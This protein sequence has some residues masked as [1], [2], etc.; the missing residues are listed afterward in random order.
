MTEPADRP[1][2]D[3]LDLSALAPD[4][5]ETERIVGGIVARLAS[6][7][8]STALPANDVLTIVGRSLPP[9][10]IAAAAALAIAGS[11]A[12]VSRDSGEPAS[13]DVVAMWAEQQHVP[14]NGELLL[15]FQGYQR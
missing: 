1:D 9:A 13:V 4:A 7:P 14:T 6:R 2:K 10:W 11:A 5:A 12:V 3:R 8:Q 15:A